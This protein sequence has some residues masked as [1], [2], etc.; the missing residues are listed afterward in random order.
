MNADMLVS[1]RNGAERKIVM[2]SLQRL[3]S[4]LAD[5]RKLLAMR[6]GRDRTADHWSP[7]EAKAVPHGRK[8]FA[9]NCGQFFGGGV[10][11]KSEGT[12]A[13]NGESISTE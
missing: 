8:H 11:S 3:V 2:I 10:P 13:R 9:R 5:L 7:A 6:A 1:S 12:L 4:G